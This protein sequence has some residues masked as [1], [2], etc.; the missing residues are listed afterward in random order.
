MVSKKYVEQRLHRM[1]V[2]M[3]LRGLAPV[4]VSVYL[5]CA[6]HF[7]ET[8]GKPLGSIK[9]MDVE[10]YMH[11]LACAGRAPRTR[12]VHLAAIRCVLRS[13]L[14]G[15][16]S[17]ALPR[18]K[19]PRRSPEILS[20]TEVDQLL[21]ATTSLK[22][23]AIFMLAYGAGLRVSEL[24]ALETTDIDSARMLI[25]VRTGK[26]GPRYVMLSPRALEALRAYWRAHRPPGPLLFPGGHQRRPS[27]PRDDPQD[28]GQGGARRGHHQDGLAAHVAAQLRNAPARVRGRRARGP[29]AARARVVGIDG[30]VPSSDD[31]ALAPDAEPARRHRHGAGAP[32]GL[33]PRVRSRPM[34]I[35][36]SGGRP[37]T[38]ARGGGHL[39][40]LPRALRA[41][42]RALAAGLPPRRDLISCRTA[43]L[44]GHVERCTACGHERPA[45]NSCRNRHCPKCQSL[46]SARWVERRLDRPPVHYFHVVFTL[47]GDLRGSCARNRAEIF[48][49][50][51]KSAAEALLALGRDPK[52][53]GRP[54]QLGITAV[55]H[56]WARDLH[57]HPHVHCIVTG[58]GLATDGSRWV[59]GAEGFPL[60]GA[61]AR[62][63]LP[64]QVSRRPRAAAGPWGAPDDGDIAL[65]AAAV[66]VSTTRAGSSTP[67]GPSAAPS[68]ST[69]TSAA[70]PIASPSAT[71]AWSASTT[72]PSSSHPRR[73]HRFA[74]PAGIHPPV[75]ATPFAPR[76][77][78]DSGIGRLAPVNVNGALAR[79][80]PLLSQ[81][82]AADG[83]DDDCD[84][85]ESPTACTRRAAVGRAAPAPDQP[86]RHAVSRV[87]AAHRRARPAARLPGRPPPHSLRPI[88]AILRCRP[89]VSSAR[90]PDSYCLRVP[91]LPCVVAPTVLAP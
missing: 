27:A 62:R 18:A 80:Q 3:Q 88:D 43:A 63:A 26:T 16:P 7:I 28:P 37:Q 32:A 22:Y 89:N 77:R 74:A 6:R 13:T 70:T 50:L 85:G 65:L 4:T 20:G 61:R 36:R 55:L 29:A 83:G 58:G 67:S 68:R 11:A 73:Q 30:H 53:L 76:L 1:R 31:R 69:A 81:A 59:R 2:W 40:S 79:A 10:Q 17:A 25:H 14:R 91:R 15:D 19:V 49:L 87:P 46:Q 57:L 82:P 44:G 75:P 41:R 9:P 45:Y 33:S 34:R 42:A 47:P 64:R 23:R 78:Q 90:A 84:D 8:V 72:P 54:A 60:S 86:R 12:N 38:G 5:R 52:W 24:A 51:L 21:A 48:D 56:T 66:R 35:G 39:P 71:A